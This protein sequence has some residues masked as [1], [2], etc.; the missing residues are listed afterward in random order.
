[1]TKQQRLKLTQSFLQQFTYQKQENL[2]SCNRVKLKLKVATLIWFC[3]LI[4]MSNVQA[5]NHLMKHVTY[6]SKWLATHGPEPNINQNGWENTS[7]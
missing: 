4:W 7:S 1:M 6:G 2:L 3:G 5:T